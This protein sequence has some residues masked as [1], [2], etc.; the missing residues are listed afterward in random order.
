M[1]KF[2]KN[3]AIGIIYVLVIP[4]GLLTR[5]WYSVFGSVLV[6]EF[7]AQTYALC[8][9]LPG[10]FTRTCY[11]KQ[12]LKKSHLD[13]YIGF[14]SLFSKME[15]V[16][17]KN[18][19]ITG[20]STIGLTEIGDNA[21]IA[22]YV[23]VLSGRY[24]HNF[25]DVSVG[26]QSI[27]TFVKIKIGTNSFVGEGCIIM[28]DIGDYSVIGAGSVVNKPIPDYV[29]AVGNPARVVKERARPKMTSK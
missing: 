18:V 2:V 4:S 11:Y 17:G 25:N 23:S 12:V 8:P 15:T 21:V 16:V 6:F 14:G 22:N 10:V 3:L 13:L 29:V 9:G 7:F 1:K 27:D 28:A 26:I 19:L 20:R 5:L 24:Q